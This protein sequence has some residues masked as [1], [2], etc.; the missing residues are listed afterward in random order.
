MGKNTARVLDIEGLPDQVAC[1]L[2]V[3]VD[4]LRTREK[5]PKGGR[6]RMKLPVRHGKIIGS[7]RRK[8]IYADV[9]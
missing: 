9:G 3:V 1:A 4:N 7:L 8:D 6:R 5:Q 2:E